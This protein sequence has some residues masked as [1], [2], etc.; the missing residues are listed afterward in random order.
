[1]RTIAFDPIAFTQ[2]N[3]WSQTDKQIHTKIIALINDIARNPF[4]GL[5]KPE[6]LKHDYQGAWSRRITDKHRLVYSVSD[7]QILILHC[8]YHYSK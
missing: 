8:K 1:M 4:T 5:G 3:E 6:P 2:F 7:Q